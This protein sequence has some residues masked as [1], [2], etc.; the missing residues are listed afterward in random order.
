MNGYT[1]T[2][3][4][5]LLIGG[6][7]CDLFGS[8]KVYLIGTVW[9]AMASAAWGLTADRRLADF[10]RVLA[11][12]IFINIPIAAAVVALGAGLPESRV[13]SVTDKIDYAGALAVVVVFLA[14]ITFAFIQPPTIGWSSPTVLAMAVAGAPGW[15]PSWSETAQRPRRCF[16][17][18]S[19]GAAVRGDQR[20]EVHRVCRVDGRRSCWR[21]SPGRV[22]LFAARLRPG[23]ASADPHHA[24]AVR[25]LRQSR[26]PDLA[27]PGP[28]LTIRL[29]LAAVQR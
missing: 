29:A 22:G 18:E 11:V 7:L 20:R 25:P 15:S 23:P 19:S 9:F 5:F 3:A 12:D 28:R 16:R 24:G 4:A 17:S 10:R 27:P 1:L 26:D 13:P 21:F 8:R 6:L 2:L 14:G